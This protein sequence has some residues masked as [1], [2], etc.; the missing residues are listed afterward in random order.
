MAFPPGATS[1]S[2]AKQDDAEITEA[3]LTKLNEAKLQFGGADCVFTRM[4]GTSAFFSSREVRDS[5][6]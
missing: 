3:D 4:S 6:H 1:G 2:L 5:A